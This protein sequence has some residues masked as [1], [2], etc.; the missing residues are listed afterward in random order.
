MPL[1]ARVTI[2]RDTNPEE[3]LDTRILNAFGRLSY[4]GFPDGGIIDKVDSIRLRGCRLEF[5]IDDLTK[6]EING[7]D[8]QLC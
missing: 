7:F 8:D 1:F 3:A 5:V 6:A 2:Y 4:W